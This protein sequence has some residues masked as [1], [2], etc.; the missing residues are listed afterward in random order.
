MCNFLDHKAEYDGHLIKKMFT[1][2]IPG[3]WMEIWKLKSN[4]VLVLENFLCFSM[5]L[6]LDTTF[7]EIPLNI[8]HN[9]TFLSF[10]SLGCHLKRG[11]GDVKWERRKCGKG[12]TFI[13]DILFSQEDLKMTDNKLIL[14]AFLSSSVRWNCCATIKGT[15]KWVERGEDCRCLPPNGIEINRII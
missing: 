7:N 14:R 1:I 10:Q 9:W 3:A 4:A 6:F 11:E 2:D 5:E 12:S 15:R 13:L 8:L